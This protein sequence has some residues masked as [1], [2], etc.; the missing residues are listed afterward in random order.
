MELYFLMLLA[1]ICS[2]ILTLLF[3]FGGG[4][5]IVP[6]VYSTIRFST[7][8]DSM[9]YAL[10]FKSA[11]ATSLLLMIVNAG[12]ASY[13]Q[14]KKGN[15]PQGYIFPL[16]YWI[17]LGAISGTVLALYSHADLLKWCFAIYLL[18][19][20]AECIYRKAQQRHHS[21]ATAQ[22][23]ALTGAEKTVG[24]LLIG[25]IA[26][27]LGVGGSVMT[28]PL[29]RRCGLDMRGAVALANPLSL[30]VALAG[31]F[32]YVVVYLFNPI[33]L[34][35]HFIGLFYLPAMLC[36]V[37]GGFIGMRCAMPWVGRL[38]NRWH[39][40]GYISLLSVVFLVIIFN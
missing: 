1:G 35:T 39:E 37:M 28:V 23:R 30:P 14:H 27:A 33:D 18:I 9:A 36:L 22:V 11:V 26:A 5:I 32:S 29:F 4:F 21:A 8:I 10:A 16:A 19:T 17:A 15:I 3:G 25:N 38:S 7:S 6:L 2:G 31:C 34:G 13:Q 40:W 12:M 20:I 24:G